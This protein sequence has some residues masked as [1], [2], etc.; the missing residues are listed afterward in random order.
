MTTPAQATLTRQAQGV[1]LMHGQD[2]RGQD[3]I[4]WHI[5][6]KLDGCRAR[7]TGAALL[8]RSGHPICAP[9]SELVKLPPGVPLDIEVFAGRRKQELA[10]RAVQYG[11]WHPAVRL[12]AFDAPAHRG[13]YVQRHSWLVMHA[14][15]DAVPSFGRVR[16]LAALA[17]LLASEQEHGAE[18]LMLHRPGVTYVPGRTPHL[19]KV[20][21]LLLL[22]SVAAD[23]CTEAA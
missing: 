16:S 6:E 8:S 18:G 7:W 14:H 10:R 17:Q 3:V 19:L 12:V 11:E 21:D 23:A 1:A 2:W 5:S 13:D 20:K 15:I 22:R 9:V 4:G